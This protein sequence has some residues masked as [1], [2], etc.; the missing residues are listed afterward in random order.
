MLYTGKGDD[1]KTKL[2]ACDQR[3]SKSSAIAEALGSIDEVNALLGL[4]KLEG[5][6]T[7]AIVG[8]SYH[9]L[10]ADVQQ[11]L[12]IIQAE[13]AGADM[14]IEATCVTKVEAWVNGIEKELPPITS[15]FVSGGTKLA[16]WCD[17]AR[18]VARRAERRVVVTVEETADAP[19]SARR[20]AR[21]PEPP[22]IAPVCPGAS[23]QSS[24]RN[25]RRKA[26]LLNS[27]PFFAIVLA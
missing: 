22:L 15:F 26:A 20:I 17:F 12:F 19:L 21:L 24:G 10:I 16:A 4:L 6:S 11:D 18:T 5:G 8:L 25:Y 23:R 27:L 2:F 3:L 13:L 1:G 9:D 14:A 7:L